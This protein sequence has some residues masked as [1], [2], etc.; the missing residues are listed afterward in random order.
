[1]IGLNN[2]GYRRNG[3]IGF[4][5]D[6]PPL[7]IYSKSS[8]RLSISD[9]RQLPFNYREIKRITN[10][11]ESTKVNLDL[12]KTLDVLIEGNAGSH[13]GFGSGTAIRLAIIESLLLI[14][15]HEYNSELLVQLSKRGGTSGIG[16]NAYFTGGF[17]FDL[18]RKYQ[19]DNRFLP[20]SANEKYKLSQPLVLAAVPMPDW[21]I[22]LCIPKGL[23]SLSE[24]EEKTFFERVC[25]ITD[26]GTFEILYHSTYGVTASILENDFETFCNS[27][28]N[29]QKCEWK[30]SERELYGERLL[31]IETKLFNSGAKAVGLSS[32]GPLLYFFSNS[33]DDVINHASKLDSELTFLVAKPS[34]SGRTINYG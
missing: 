29:L 16:I 6:T 26:Q 19:L 5:I 17:I 28:N 2:E 22:G 33:I 3:G 34:N 11:L 31:E 12:S 8:N 9:K 27:I 25:P 10:L 13:L 32:M 30:R 1:M 24:E 20:S 18:G 15:E 14:N 21:Q 4:S 7:K 23:A